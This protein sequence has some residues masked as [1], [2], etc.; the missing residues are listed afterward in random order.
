MRRY[1]FIERINNPYKIKTLISID[2][3]IYYLDTYFDSMLSHITNKKLLNKKINFFITY[4]II[5]KDGYIKILKNNGGMSIG[6]IKCIN[7]LLLSKKE[8]DNVLQSKAKNSY[9]SNKIDIKSFVRYIVVKSLK[10][11]KCLNNKSI[12]SWKDECISLIIK[13]ERNQWNN[14]LSNFN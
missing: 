1:G 7:Y 4:K 13:D 12:L 8:F 9:V 6:L 5:R 2:D 3:I 10:D 11:I 14:L